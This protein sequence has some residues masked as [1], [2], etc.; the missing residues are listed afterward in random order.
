MWRVVARNANIK[1]D[2]WLYSTTFPHHH[3]AEACAGQWLRWGLTGLDVY[4]EVLI[5]KKWEPTLL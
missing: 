2:H 1:E 3:L 4:I 5:G